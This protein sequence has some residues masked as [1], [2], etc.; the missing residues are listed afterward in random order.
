MRTGAAVQQ[1]SVAAANAWF[2]AEQ[3]SVLNPLGYV[4]PQRISL[5]VTKHSLFVLIGLDR[6][7]FETV[8]PDGADA[9]DLS[10]VTAN[11]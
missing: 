2:Q 6:K 8:L 5:D 10:M 9:V 7:C 1:A 4:C 11:L 3:L